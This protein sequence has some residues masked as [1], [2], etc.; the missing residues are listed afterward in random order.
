MKTKT[1]YKSPHRR[2]ICIESSAGKSFVLLDQRGRFIRE[3]PADFS[4]VEYI[5]QQKKLS[6]AVVAAT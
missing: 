4:P 2:V 5:K 1:V 3:M 6:A